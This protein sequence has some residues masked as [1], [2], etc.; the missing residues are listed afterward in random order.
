M[1]EF[2]EDMKKMYL[3]AMSKLSPEDAESQRI[4]LYEVGRSGD[5][6]FFK[7][8]IDAATSTDAL[9]QVYDT[10]VEFGKY[11]N[12]ELVLDGFLKKYP[13]K[14]SITYQAAADAKKVLHKLNEQKRTE[15]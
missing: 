9:N 13:E 12:A 6:E 4:M 3:D 7:S 8:I 14:N 11:G 1:T 15:N 2:T 5:S 10:F